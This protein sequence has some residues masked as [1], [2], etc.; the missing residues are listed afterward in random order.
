M[1]ASTATRWLGIF[2]FLGGSL[3]IFIV[4]MQNISEGIKLM[5]WL[6]L[7]FMMVGQIG[8]YRHQRETKDRFGRLTSIIIIIGIFLVD[9]VLG[10]RFTK[11]LLQQDDTQFVRDTHLT[12]LM[13]WMILI[14]GWILFGLINAIKGVFPRWAGLIL[15]FGA[16]AM[17]IPII[18]PVVAGQLSVLHFLVHLQNIDFTPLIGLSYLLLGWIIWWKKPAKNTTKVTPADTTSTPADTTKKPVKTVTKNTTK[19]LIP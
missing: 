18:G 16:V 15:A 7:L 1:S 4:F 8:F 14:T 17:T 6:P 12:Y 13:S 10:V 9:M 11:Y 19:S 5:S 2:G 3:Y